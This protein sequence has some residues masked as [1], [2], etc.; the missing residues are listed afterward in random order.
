MPKFWL[1]KSEPDV[2][3]F[4]DLHRLGKTAWEGVRNYQARNLMREQKVGDGV[5][6]YHSNAKPSGIIGVARVVRES[7]PDTTQF[8]P[9][10]EYF[11]AKATRDKPRWFMVDVAY[12]APLPRLISLAELH[13]VTGLKDMVLL[14]RPRLSV[15]PVTPNEWR[16]ITK[17]L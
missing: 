3:S 16:L 4:A 14:H 9:K 17:V 2:F 10:S 12:E 1:M 8:D 15:Q 5:L 11:D 13:T 7:Y 6:F